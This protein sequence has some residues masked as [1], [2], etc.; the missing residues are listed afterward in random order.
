MSFN[1]QVDEI[2]DMATYSHKKIYSTKVREEKNGNL[3]IL[4]LY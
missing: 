3:L 2:M 1:F 4:F